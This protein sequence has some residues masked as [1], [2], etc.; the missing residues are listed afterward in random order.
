[1]KFNDIEW[2]LGC[3]LGSGKLSVERVVQYSWNT[4]CF[5]H[6]QSQ[7]SIKSCLFPAKQDSNQILHS[8]AA[9]NDPP[10]TPIISSTQYT[11]FLQ[12]FLSGKFG[13][14]YQIMC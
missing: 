10:D 2:D 1:M 3:L 4:D 8:P 6:A 9:E 7:F 14:R 11:T 12:H 5:F 13:K